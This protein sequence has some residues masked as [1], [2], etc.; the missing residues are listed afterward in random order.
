MPFSD[1]NFNDF[2]REFLANIK[3]ELPGNSFK[4]SDFEAAYNKS[5]ISITKP[6]QYL[7]NED[8]ELTWIN[9]FKKVLFHIFKIT[10]DP[11]CTITSY[12][13]AVGI[14]KIVKID[15]RD[16]LESSKKDSYW[17]RKVSG[18]I[19]PKKFSTS[20]NE[21]DMC[22]Y[23][24]RFVVFVVDLMLGFVNL[25]ISRLRKNLRFMSRNFNSDNFAYKDVSNV[26]EL[27]NFK[28]F[29]R[30]K[31]KKKIPINTVPLLTS[32]HS[33]TV[34]NLEELELLKKEL[35]RVTF[36]PF[37]NIVK[38]SG[39]INYEGVYP[40][41]LLLGDHDYSE[42]FNFYKK[43][44]LLKK[45]PTY[46]APIYR[47]WY[48]DF[49]G[50]TLL[51]ELKE[52]GFKFNKNRIKFGDVHHILLTSY[53]CEKEGVKL[54]IKMHHNV[55]E[56][57]FNVQYIEGKFHKLN[58][59]YRKRENK[60]C[61]IMLPNP[62]SDD[63]NEVRK[64]YD[65]LVKEKLQSGEFINAYIISPR[66]E[67][68]FPSSVIV[69]PFASNADLSLKNVIQSSLVFVEGDSKMYSK[70]CPICGS[71]VDGEW[72]DGNCHCLECN[73]VWTSL[74]SGDNHQY[75]NTIWLKAI[76]RIV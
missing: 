25:N 74:I 19:F 56:L 57:T 43:Y 12:K 3:N 60:I 41:N 40:T 32:N 55:I 23:E 18:Q 54:N 52:L 16:V 66:E 72:D 35:H 28:Q 71:R 62:K 46:K 53:N 49:V 29:T 9:D 34:K 63:P 17:D 8:E 51:M 64:L 42:I 58:N 15:S 31:S 1:K 6:E 24:N 30:I 76:K 61:L 33:V 26:M 47:P 38:K 65:S 37:Y 69:S 13:E 11:R 68:N 20:I 10:N 75:Q 22:I 5:T 2:L 44:L 50:L 48:Y 59:L 45:T 21:R 39:Q 7:I 70:L 73:S 4:F 27:A 14:E 67:F 36:T